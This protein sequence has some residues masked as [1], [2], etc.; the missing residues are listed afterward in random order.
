MSYKRLLV[1]NRWPSSGSYFVVEGHAYWHFLDNVR[2]MYESDGNSAHLRLYV[3][4][5]KMRLMRK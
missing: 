4:M 5:E 3:A 1:C 2:C